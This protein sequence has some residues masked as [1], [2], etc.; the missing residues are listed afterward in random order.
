[1]KI[2][3]LHILWV[4]CN[5]LSTKQNE[6]SESSTYVSLLGNRSNYNSCLFE[7]FLEY[8]SFKVEENKIFIFNDD[9]VPYEDYTN[10]DFS[11]V[12][13]VLL[14]FGEK[15]LEQWI[16]TEVNRQLKEQE[17]EKLQQKESIKLQIERLQKQLKTEK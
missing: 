16:E 14:D 1:M 10:D 17:V 12:P 15:E 6:L 5:M 7:R 9:G 13:I 2:L 11:Y 8:Y 4:I 3:N